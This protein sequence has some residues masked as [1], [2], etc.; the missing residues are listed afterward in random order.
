MPNVTNSLSASI[1]STDDTTQNV[2]I[3]LGTGNPAFNSTFGEYI[4]YGSCGVGGANLYFP[5]TPV[6]QF[7]FKNNDPAKLITINWTPQGSGLVTVID[8]SPGDQILF[9]QA[10]GGANAGITT[11]TVSASS[12][13]ALFEY[14]AGG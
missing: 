9:W 2:P 4:R 10:V 5:Q 12:G 7:Y 13:T 11:C 14:F 3:N 8:L 1:L 6:Y